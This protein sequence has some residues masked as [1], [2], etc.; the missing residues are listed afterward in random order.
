[1]KK[2]VFSTSLVK[3]HHGSS[4]YH[5]VR[6][7]GMHLHTIVY[8]VACLPV[9]WLSCGFLWT[10]LI[11]EFWIPVAP[12]S[13]VFSTSQDSQGTINILKEAHNRA[14]KQDEMVAEDVGLIC[15][16]YTQLS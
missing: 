9:C 8:H 5:P 10:S 2:N 16:L 14:S 7:Q 11:L 12:I 13:L 1:M 3:E 4:L 15:T 6:D